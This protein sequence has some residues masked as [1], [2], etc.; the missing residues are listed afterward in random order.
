MKSHLWLIRFIGLI[1][2]RRLRA[3]WRQEWEA[4]LRCR[5]MTLAEWDKLDWRNKLD[6]LRRSIGAFT[7]ALL[8]QPRRLEEEMFQDLRLGFRMLRTQPAFSLAA[9][10]ALALGIGATTLIFSVVNAV[11]LRP[12]P[13]RDADR[14][15]RLE[16]Q[17]R[18]GRPS[19]VSYANFLDLGEQTASLEHIAASRFWT[20]NL[21]G[22]NREPEQVPSAFASASFFHALGVAPLLGRTFSPEEDRPGGAPVVVL[23]HKLWQRRFNGNPNIVGQTIRVSD[24]DRTVVGVMPHGFQ[25]PTNTQLWTPLI[26]GGSLRDNRRSHLLT[27]IARLKPGATTEQAQAEL[28]A[29][30]A[31][32]EQANP[33]VDPQLTLGAIRL[34]ERMVG[35]I[36]PALLT[37]LAAVG[38]LLLIACANVANLLLARSAAREKEMAIRAALGAGRLRLLRQLLTESSLL[39]LLGGALGLVIAY[40]GVRFIVTLNP[41]ALPR[42]NEVTIDAS[43]LVFA[44]ATSLA[45]SALFG[46]AP[47][48]QLPSHSLQGALKE[49]GR[50]SA[51]IGRRRLRHGLI[52]AEVALAA[53][54]LAGAGLLGTS[55]W[56]LL[57]VEHGFDPQ[58]VLTMN[59][60]LS[61]TRYPQDAQQTAFLKQVL[62]RTASVPGVRVAGLNTSL[63]MTG[64]AATDFEVVGHS[65]VASGA[66][67]LADIRSVD[68]NYFRAMSI[69]LRAGRVFTER[70]TADAPRVMLINETLARRHFP[71]ES[72]LGR[73]IT[74]KDWG[75]PLTGEIVGVVADVKE[76][77]LDAETSAEIYWP[78]QQFPNAFNALVVKTD[79]D[80]TGVANAVKAQIWAVDSVQPIAN[81]ATM[82]EVIATS[83]ADRRFNLLLFGVFAALALLLAAVGIYGVISYTVSQRTHEIGIRMALGAQA[84]NV[85]ALVF[86]QGMTLVGAGIV[87]GLAGAFALTRLMKGLL[88]GV[89]ATDPLTFALIP[90]ALGVVAGLACYLP[91][92]RAT[93]VNPLAALHHE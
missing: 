51:G 68:P 7:D 19:N 20:G 57:R 74:M 23:S 17:H 65:P 47:V 43:V 90:L 50:S 9:I 1:V 77:G 10:V 30:A 18:H 66:E 93:K 61:P 79:G 86:R 5:E 46:I 21:G 67:R 31:R 88:F 33:N 48:L 89:T 32:I 52:V 54:L 34:Q 59:L 36:R 62:E 13:Y 45:T 24:V 40:W 55:F 41:F 91:A 69:P 81:I 28:A 92:R 71:G 26:A 53:M 42:I 75:P 78:Y 37:L 83:V 38:C 14:I 60:F 56:K 64:G 12:L 44:L 2:P 16:E 11:L 6:L 80:P 72:P 63:P 22:D 15:V 25:L 49:S 84:H 76:N 8:L 82:E 73:S 35:G 39:G 70:D 85:L 29:A 3:D 87:L 58:N 4:E 27:V